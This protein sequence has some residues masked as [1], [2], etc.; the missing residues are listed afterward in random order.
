MY[1]YRLAVNKSC[2]KRRKTV[3]IIHKL[4]AATTDAN[5]FV[6]QQQQQQA[7]RQEEDTVYILSRF[8]LSAE[9]FG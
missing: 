8:R 7:V 3:Y 5:D 9:Q 4:P 6:L 2:S 1:F